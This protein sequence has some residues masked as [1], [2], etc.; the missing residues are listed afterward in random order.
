MSADRIEVPE[1]YG[2]KIAVFSR[3]S[4]LEELF[5]HG[6]GL[7]IWVCRANRLVFCALELVAVEGGTRGEDHIL[8]AM[9]QHALEERDR[10]TNVVLIVLHWH[11]NA[12]TD[13]LEACEVNHRLDRTVA[14]ED[15][16]EHAL[17]ANID[18]LED[19]HFVDFPS[20]GLHALKADG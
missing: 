3:H 6:L 2:G 4:V 7:S 9:L 5:D 12:L 19:D 16:I 17:M 8:A 18:F 15:V 11:A 10:S 14:S 1:A 20:D 13:C